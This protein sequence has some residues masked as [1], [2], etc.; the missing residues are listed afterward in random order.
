[1]KKNNLQTFVLALCGN[2]LLLLGGCLGKH[3]SYGIINSPVMSIDNKYIIALVAE[4]E[5]L[6]QQ[7]N[8]GFVKTTYR[9]SYWLKQFET[10]TGKLVKKK[11]LL[12]ASESDPLSITCYG[13]YENTIW[14][15]VNGLTAYDI[16]SLEEVSNEKKITAANGLKNH[17]FP[18]DGRLIYPAVENGYIDFIAGNGEKYRLSLADIRISNKALADKQEPGKE[19]NYIQSLHDDEYGTRCDT[20]LDKVYMLAKDST[21]A[22]LISPANAEVNEVAYPM[23]LFTAHFNM[24]K[25]GNHN[26][27]SYEAIQRL[28][29]HTFLNP[30]FAK[31]T[32]KDQVIHLSNPGGF[33]IIHQD[34]LGERSKA[35]VTRIDTNGKTVWES[36][37]GISTKISACSY[38]NNYCFIV[39][40]KDYMFSPHIGKDALCIINTA[41][42]KITR[43]LLS[44]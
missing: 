11:K 43:P 38:K 33:I 8:G 35:L 19:K 36:P 21:A 14:L 7:E 29:D 1:M 6:S 27:F 12:S 34:V 10:A 42:G 4:S 5:G 39:A 24:R 15:Y 41:S 2:L 26:S 13:S 40:N 3:T 17:I 20:L 37:A 16:N 30:C 28:T 22:A 31:D 32:D 25:L 23:K 9:N 44:E 18:F